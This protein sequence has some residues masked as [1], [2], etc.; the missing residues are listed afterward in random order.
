M[1]IISWSYIGLG[2]RSVALKLKYIIRYYKSNALFLSEALVHS[3]KTGEFCCLLGFDSYLAISGLRRSGCLAL[4][5]LNV[6]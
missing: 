2:N 4:F 1:S 5:W 6:E 3:N